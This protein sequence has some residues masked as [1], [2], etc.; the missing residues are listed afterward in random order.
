MR[1][2]TARKGE[3]V[4]VCMRAVGD[5][6]EVFG[7]Y[8]VLNTASSD[9]E[10]IIAWGNRQLYIPM[11]CVSKAAD[12]RYTLTPSVRRELGSDM[13]RRMTATERKA[14]YLTM[15]AE[16]LFWEWV[17]AQKDGDADPKDILESGQAYTASL[18]EAE[19]WHTKAGEV[20]ERRY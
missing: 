7:F 4:L 10:I 20:Q 15:Q 9:T 5:D 1:Q 16:H 3:I 19:E 6:P 11:H 12:T 2:F 8:E 14:Y 17:D 13:G 18:R